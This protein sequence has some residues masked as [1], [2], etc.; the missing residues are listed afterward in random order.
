MGRIWNYMLV[1]TAWLI[2]QQHSF[3]TLFRKEYEWV[4]SQ[5]KPWLQN[6]DNEMPSWRC[7]LTPP[8]NDNGGTCD[9]LCTHDCAEA[10]ANSS[11]IDHV[12]ML[13][14][15]DAFQQN[16]KQWDAAGVTL[17]ARWSLASM[18]KWMWQED[19]I[20]SFNSKR[21]FS[22]TVTNK[23]K[24]YNTFQCHLGMLWKR[25]WWISP[26]RMVPVYQLQWQQDPWA[27]I[28]LIWN[29]SPANEQ[30]C[31]FKQASE[32]RQLWG[33][34]PVKQTRNLLIIQECQLLLGKAGKMKWMYPRMSSVYHLQRRPQTLV[35]F[36]WCSSAHSN[37]PILLLK[38]SIR[39]QAT[40]CISMHPLD[41]CS[42]DYSRSHVKCLLLFIEHHTGTVKLHFICLEDHSNLVGH[43]L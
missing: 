16:R 24:Q 43:L 1:P 14:K 29:S 19:S 21:C 12:L 37:E 39:E 9:N 36:F 2:I 22:Y 6:F 17:M 28:T 38:V 26:R 20:W 32:N 4:K 18:I 35:R 10:L 5:Q 3:S 40:A 7:V 11:Q 42:W 41:C 23:N 30:S 27:L 15:Y 31:C 34:C 25:M 13:Q 8:S 33:W